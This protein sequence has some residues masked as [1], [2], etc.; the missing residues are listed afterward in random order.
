MIES[1]RTGDIETA[2]AISGAPGAPVVAFS[3]SLACAMLMWEPQVAAL[4]R[5]YRVLRYDTRGHGASSAPTGRY[6]LEML[7]GDFVALLDALG[8]DEVHFVGLSMGGMIGQALALD[9]RQRLKSLV[10][11]DT[12]ASIPEAAQPTWEQRIAT[13]RAAGMAGVVDATLERWFTAPFRARGSAVLEDVRRQILTTPVAGYVG[14]SEA[15]RA[16]AYRER[17]GEIDL[18]ALVMVGAE[19]PSTPVAAAR[20]I[21]ERIRGSLL[22]IVPE[23]AHL[24]NLEQPEAFNA[25]LLA[26]LDARRD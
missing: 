3:H 20:A 21:Q 8:I 17:L 16:L 10:L 6:S 25:A 2:Y 14:C 15:I 7:A 9:H 19:D 22:E 24:A 4:E 26:F 13:V 23:A 12:M 1:V 18:P 5:R 11:C